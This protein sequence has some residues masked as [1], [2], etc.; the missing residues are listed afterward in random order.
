MQKKGIKLSTTYFTSAFSEG[1]EADILINKKKPKVPKVPLRFM[2][3]E[4]IPHIQ[5]QSG[6]QS[7]GN[8][9]LKSKMFQLHVYNYILV[10]NIFW[11]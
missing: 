11:Y 2:S 9:L 1:K 4:Q 8:K 5:V 6:K 3:E 10:L 7:L